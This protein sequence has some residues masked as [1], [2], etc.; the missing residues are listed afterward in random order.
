MASTP[1]PT[2]RT[3][4][5][6][7]STYG[8]HDFSPEQKDLI[9]AQIM[10]YLGWESFLRVPGEPLRTDNEHFHFQVKKGTVYPPIT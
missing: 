4:L 6:T 1:A 2:I 8:Q 3:T 7:R 10:N 9:L 5:G